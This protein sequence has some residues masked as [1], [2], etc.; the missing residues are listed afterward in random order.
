MPDFPYI[1]ARVRA[2][3]SRLL[4]AAQLDELLGAPTLP[5]FLQ[6]LASTPYAGDLQEALVRFE[7]VRAVDEALAR[8]LHRTTRKILGFA[9]GRPRALIE[10][11]LLRWDLV[12][13]RVI[14]RGKH[15]GRS[16]DEVMAALLPAGT[17]GEAALKEM[18]TAP[19]IAGVV[20]TLEAV[21]HPFAP[22]M[23]EAMAGYAGNQDLLAFELLLDRAYVERGLRQT[24]GRSGD[25]AVLREVLQAEIDAA[26]AKTALKLGSAGGLDEEA[27]LRFFIPGGVLLPADLFLALSASSTRASAWRRLR[28]NG[29]PIRDLPETPIEF[30]RALDLATAQALAGRYSGDPLGLDIVIGY[31]ALKTY[32]VANLRLVARGAFLGLPREAVRREMVRV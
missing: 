24:R 29:F 13:L 15:A 5:A 11:V 27:L 9:D 18:V 17:L 7:G 12:N 2:M 19:D 30:E 23:A 14:V 4:T 25:A 20:G 32:E 26:N 1:N 31:L 3:R 8:N 10:V 22:V 21:G 16:G 28:I 6:A